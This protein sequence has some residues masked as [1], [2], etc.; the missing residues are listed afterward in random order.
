MWVGQAT[1]VAGAERR[2]QVARGLNVAAQ[3]AVISVLI[4]GMLCKELHAPV[5]ACCRSRD[6]IKRTMATRACRTFG[7]LLLQALRMLSLNLP[8]D[9]T[10]CS[11]VPAMRDLYCRL[12]ACSASCSFHKVDRPLPGSAAPSCFWPHFWIAHKAYI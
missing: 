5:Q 3:N 11:V 7:R 1:V 8:S 12:S 4:F 6:S 2:L 9:T 10:E